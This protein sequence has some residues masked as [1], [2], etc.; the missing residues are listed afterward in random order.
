MQTRPISWHNEIRHCW[1]P[2]DSGNYGCSERS[3]AEGRTDARTPTYPATHE[4]QSHWQ[5][6]A[7]QIDDLSVWHRDGNG[8]LLT[9]IRAASASWSD[10]RS[11]AQLETGAT[12]IDEE[13]QYGTA[14]CKELTLKTWDVN[15]KHVLELLQFDATCRSGKLFEVVV[16]AVKAW[17]LERRATTSTLTRVRPPECE[18]LWIGLDSDKGSAF[19][20]GFEIAGYALGLLFRKEPLILAQCE[21]LFIWLLP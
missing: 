17:Y 8:N 3:D 20:V 16:N 11:I 14:W 2:S 9:G 21:E 12:V 5:V 13:L 15:S 4:R 6:A 19:Q 10:S 1:L 7:G 18:P